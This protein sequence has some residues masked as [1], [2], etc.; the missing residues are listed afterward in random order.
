M[1]RFRPHRFDTT[2]KKPY[3]DY[4]PKRKAGTSDVKGCR[5]AES[6]RER[7]FKVNHEKILPDRLLNIKKEE[8]DK[9]INKHKK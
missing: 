9:V 4:Q 2:E 5:G 6:V 3:L 8:I 7:W 1:F